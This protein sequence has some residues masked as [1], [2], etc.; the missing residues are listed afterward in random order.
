[1]SILDHRD[2]ITFVIKCTETFHGNP[3]QDFLHQIFR[4][5]KIEINFLQI[6]CIYI[7]IMFEEEHSPPNNRKRF[8]CIHFGLNL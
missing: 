5:N 6:K 3:P 4:P 1:M 8:T 2:P 7:K